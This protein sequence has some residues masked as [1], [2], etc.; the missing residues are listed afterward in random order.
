LFQKKGGPLGEGVVINL[1]SPFNATAIIVALP[2]YGK[3]QLKNPSFLLSLRV[4]CCY[5]KDFQTQ[6]KKEKKKTETYLK[7][8]PKHQKDSS[9]RLQAQEADI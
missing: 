2:L 6:K 7:K 9:P 1:Y 8:K 4:D 5:Y 3:I